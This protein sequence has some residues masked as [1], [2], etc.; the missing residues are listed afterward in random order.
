M[1]IVSTANTN[2]SNSE[3]VLF[4]QDIDLYNQRVIVIAQCGSS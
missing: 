3:T 2:A 1:N 4:I